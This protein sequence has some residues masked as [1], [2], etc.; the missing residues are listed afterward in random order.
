MLV[1]FPLVCLL[2]LVGCFDGAEGDVDGDGWWVQDGDCDDH[3]A[4][5]S[6]AATEIP[7]D[8]IDQDCDGFDS[9]DLID[10][11]GDG[12]PASEDCD[13]NDW[14]RSPLLPEVCDG[15]DNDCDLVV[16]DG[17][18]GDGDGVTVCGPDGS[19]GTTDDDCD[20]SD[21]QLY[22][23][24]VEICDGDDEDCDGAIDELYDAD[25]DSTTTCGDDGVP[26]TADDDCDDDDPSV[27]PGIWDDCDGLDVNCNGLVDED[28]DDGGGGD[29]SWYCYA[30]ADGDGI[31]GSGTVVTTDADCADPG[32]SGVT[33]DCNDGNGAVYPGAIDQ[34]GNGVDE[35]CDG[36]DQV[37]SCA[38]ATLYADEGEPNNSSTQTNLVVTGDGHVELDG[39][40]SSCG[41]GGDQDWFSVSFGCS[42]PVTYVL[43]WP[44]S[45]SNLDLAV[46]GSASASESGGSMS[47]PV[48]TSTTASTGSMV[49]AVS[50]ASGDATPYTLTID[51]D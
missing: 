15:R 51:W 9:V 32:E 19:A 28:C 45:S 26:G 46:S 24:N 36:A 23:G 10:A 42:G 8:G 38:G 4:G 29:D 14:G 1:R 6:P 35:D 33:G 7:G 25:G 11:D 49:I 50:C 18:D 31:G 2:L 44:G 40:V 41:G 43:D 37:S 22:P 21:A 12:S 16:D 47:G 48:E 3:D 30:D 27:E 34:P 5:I 17:F 20:D 39:V 13:D